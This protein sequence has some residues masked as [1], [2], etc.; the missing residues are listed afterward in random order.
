[1]TEKWSFRAGPRGPQ[2]PPDGTSWSWSTMEDATNEPL[3]NTTEKPSQLSQNNCREE[4]MLSRFFSPTMETLAPGVRYSWYLK[5]V[6]SDPWSYLTWEGSFPQVI[7]SYEVLERMRKY[8]PCG[9]TLINGCVQ[10]NNSKVSGEN[11]HCRLH[12]CSL[13]EKVDAL[14]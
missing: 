14:L 12:C 5:T 3:L 2:S 6:Y 4:P 7:V 13:T 9:Q 11:M 8:S 1:M 10:E